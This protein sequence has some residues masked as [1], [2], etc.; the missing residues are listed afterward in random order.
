MNCVI[1]EIRKPRRHCPGV[2]GEI[3]SICC[4]QEREETINCPLDCVYLKEARTRE[5]SEPIDPERMPNRD[6]RISER[7]MQEHERLFV[8]TGTVLLEAALD[9]GAID[10]DVR[11]A[12][13]ALIRT[14]RTLASGLYYDSRP[15]NLIAAGIYDRFQER[16]ATLRKE[17]SESSGPVIRDAEVLAALVF[18]ER[19]ELQT[20]N[21]R[22]RGRAFIDFA[23]ANFPT[24]KEASAGHGASPLIQV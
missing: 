12:L 14:F 15:A 11:E 21:G 19:A 20:N 16:L 2:S 9:G 7:F 3:C 10:Y 1:C 8:F 6:I 17:F 13:D 18:F 22:K 5:K 4:G 23:R 24:R